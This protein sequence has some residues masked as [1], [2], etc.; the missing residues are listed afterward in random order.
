VSYGSR[1]NEVVDT[2]VCE[3]A[4]YKDRIA[5]DIYFRKIAKIQSED[6]EGDHILYTNFE[7]EKELGMGALTSLIPLGV[8]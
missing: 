6:P 4:Q 8:V 2:A 7:I 5:L 3:F 1:D